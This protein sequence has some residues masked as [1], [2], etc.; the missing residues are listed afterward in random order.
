MPKYINF[1]PE[2]RLY[3]D[4]IMTYPQALDKLR[5]FVS[6]PKLKLKS[7]VFGNN[8]YLYS[9]NLK[10]ILEYTNTPNREVIKLLLDIL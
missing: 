3:L 8:P 9:D 2:H 4:T 6:N 1:T 5:N 7:P 10:N